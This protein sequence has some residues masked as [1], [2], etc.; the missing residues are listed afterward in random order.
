MTT[1]PIPM[2]FTVFIS[3]SLPTLDKPPLVYT[4]QFKPV[5]PKKENAGEVFA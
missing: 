4:I 3:I 2:N 5:K 1:A